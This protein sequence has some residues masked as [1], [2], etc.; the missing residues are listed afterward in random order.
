MVEEYLDSMAVLYLQEHNSI[1][2]A[3]I[4]KSRRKQYKWQKKVR[5]PA[6]LGD[7][8]RPGGLK[9]WLPPVDTVPEA[10]MM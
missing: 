5:G 7:R 4:S 2:V 9:T 3:L 1:F 10:C 8:R 6:W